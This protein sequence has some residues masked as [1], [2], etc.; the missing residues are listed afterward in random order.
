MSGQFRHG[1]SLR[2]DGGT[3]VVPGPSCL[4][5]EYMRDGER[6]AL[7]PVDGVRHL[8]LVDRTP[9]FEIPVDQVGVVCDLVA[10]LGDL[11]KAAAQRLL[12][13]CRAPLEEL[14]SIV[15]FT[16]GGLLEIGSA[17]AAACAGV[18]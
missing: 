17:V 14:P 13:E 6:D 18:G 12:V 1:P 3:P 7:D 16:L 15:T 2:G 4:V 9:L 5:I 10:A 11:Q 8:G